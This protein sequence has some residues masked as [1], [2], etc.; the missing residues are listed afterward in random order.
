VL[1]ETGGVWPHRT[2]AGTAS[3]TNIASPRGNPHAGSRAIAIALTPDGNGTWVAWSGRARVDDFHFAF[4]AF[5]PITGVDWNRCNGFLWRFDSRNAPAGALGLYEELFDYA[6][7][8]LGVPFTYAGT[9]GDEIPP[10]NTIVVGWRDLSGVSTADSS[11]VLGATQP[12]PPNRAWVWLASN[13]S[14]LL[15]P[16]GS[17]YDWT[18]PGWGQV[19][20]HELGHALGLDHI[21]DPASVMNPSS[22]ILLHWGQGD[23]AGIRGTTAC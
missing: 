7:R 14:L 13:H 15:P 1:D 3:G 8:V 16:P 22:N 19:A 6:S 5:R 17:S 11:Y 23:L 4:G 2:S 18:P 10:P 9:I 20:I 21:D 12:L